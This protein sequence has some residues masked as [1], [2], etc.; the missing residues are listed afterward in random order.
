MLVGLH[1]AQLAFCSNNQVWLHSSKHTRKGKKQNMLMFSHI[2][3][4][5][6]P[7]NRQFLLLHEK[8]ILEKSPIA[9]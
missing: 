4:Q 7:T 8:I 5:E 2:Q 6:K 3:R 1:N 9:Q